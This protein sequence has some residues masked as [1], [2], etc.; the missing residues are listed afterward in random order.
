MW[1]RDGAKRNK[2]PK[3]I[4][5]WV[6]S[7]EIELYIHIKKMD[8]LQCNFPFPAKFFDRWWTEN[9]S[10]RHSNWIRTITKT[11]KR[12]RVTERIETNVQCRKKNDIEDKKKIL[13]MC[14]KTELVFQL[15][16]FDTL[17]LIKC[18]ELKKTILGRIEKVSWHLKWIKSGHQEWKRKRVHRK[19][20]ES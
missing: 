4:K 15:H 17:T 7:N 11:S 3:W 5:R 20:K 8:W 1:K 6:M 14:H 10:N 12:V 19:P 16:L 2:K 9:E 18:M 13:T